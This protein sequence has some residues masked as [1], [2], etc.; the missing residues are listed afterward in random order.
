ME[1]LL[2]LSGQVA[3]GIETWMSRGWREVILRK[4]KLG[5]GALLPSCPLSPPVPQDLPRAPSTAPSRAIDSL[6]S[7]SSTETPTG[8]KGL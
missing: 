7:H 6:H 3:G 4:E 8:P 2:L 1:G 5:K